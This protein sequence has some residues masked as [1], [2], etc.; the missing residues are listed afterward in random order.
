MF[1]KFRCQCD[2]RKPISGPKREVVS[3]LKKNRDCALPKKMVPAHK[4]VNLH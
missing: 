3:F 4:K 2:Q 1:G